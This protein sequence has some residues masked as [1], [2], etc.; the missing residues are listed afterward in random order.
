M[1]FALLLRSSSYSMSQAPPFFVL[2]KDE[3]SIGRRGDFKLDTRQGHEISRIHATVTRTVENGDTVW[4][5]EDSCSLNGTFINAIKIDRQILQPYDEIVFGGGP[6]FK[7]G[8]I[9]TFSEDSFCRYSFLP[10][11][12]LVRFPSTVDS[13]AGSSDSQSDEVCAICYHPMVLS[14]TLPC[15]HR[16]CTSCL[17]RWGDHCSQQGRPV[18]C[19]MCRSGFLYCELTTSDVSFYP[20]HLDVWSLESFMRI[21]NIGHIRAFKSCSIW[22]KWRD[23]HRGWFRRTLF[24]LN[25]WYWR[26]VF[27]HLAKATVAHVLVA[28]ADE[29]EQAMRNFGIEPGNNLGENRRKI[30]LRL[31][32]EYWSR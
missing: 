26:I 32:H 4:T 18:V 31:Y 28:S 14:K 19:P 6:D 11:A 22:T 9:F 13:S 16:F 21:L 3:T 12:P 25:Q 29:V 23:G 1:G 15:K 8:D 20:D 27:L 5:L 24:S 17:R 7:T 10:I 2:H 30:M